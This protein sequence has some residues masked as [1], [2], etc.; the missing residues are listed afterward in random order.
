[1][2][3]KVTLFSE[4]SDAQLDLLDARSIVRTYPKGSII[5]N[6]G[7]Q[8][9]ALFVIQSGSVKTYLSETNGKE[10]LLSTQGP[11]DY[12]GELALFDDAPRSASVAVVEPCKVTIISKATLRDTLHERP[13]IALVLLKGLA[14]RIR[15][16][17]ENVRTLTLLDVFGRLVA[18]LYSLAKATG[19]GKH[20]IEQKLT[21]QD[22][23]NRIGASR[24]MVSRIMNDLVKGGYIEVGQKQILI[25]KKIPSSW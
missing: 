11:G 17:T 19:D 23:A 24:E 12:F 25:C 14:A 15:A 1:M 4:L 9:N 20:L 7:E 22:L 8:G 5:V 18:T 13:E 3:R 21:Q 6:E 16:L 10:V 2:L